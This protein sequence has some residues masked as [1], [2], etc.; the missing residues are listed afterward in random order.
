VRQPL[1]LYPSLSSVFFLPAV[2]RNVS[3]YELTLDCFVLN[4]SYNSLKVKYGQML[5]RSPYM[6]AYVVMRYPYVQAKRRKIT[7]AQMMDSV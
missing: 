3:F 4:I 2:G 6:S 5:K 1:V 7:M